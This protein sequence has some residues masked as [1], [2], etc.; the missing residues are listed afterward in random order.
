FFLEMNTRLQVEHPVTELTTR[1]DICKAMFRL[2]AGEKL[3]F[4][5]DDVPQEGHAIECRIIAEDPFNGFMP[6]AGV[7]R[8]FTP[9]TGPGVRVDAGFA[10]GVEIG[11]HYDSLLAKLITWGRDRDEAI[12][13]MQHA[14]DDFHIV[15]PQTCIPF[16]K[17]M[18]ADADYV[19][20]HMTVHSAE[21]K[22]KDGLMGG[23]RTDDRQVAAALV[24]AIDVLGAKPRR[25]G[26]SAGSNGS[27]AAAA[28]NGSAATVGHEQD[29]WRLAGR[30]GAGARSR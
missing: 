6:G 20:G 30:S 16:H 15:G 14:L 9:P 13:R 8:E 4:G 26:A 18:L 17:K 27:S 25:D 10:T 23:E 22:L 5:Q 3:W 28:T 7:L 19:A 12:V 11:T 1:I 24:A 29:A 2:A 21:K